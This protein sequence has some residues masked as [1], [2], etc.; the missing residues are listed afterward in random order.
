MPHSTQIIARPTSP[1]LR[2]FR[3]AVSL[4]SH[5]THSM[6]RL[7]H[8]RSIAALFRGLWWTP[9]LAPAPALRLERGQI[10]GLGLRPLVSITDHDNIDAPLLLRA[11]DGSRD[12]PVSVEWTVP[13]GS[14]FFHLG[15]HN[16]PPRR[17][18][19]RMRVL[20]GFTAQPNAADLPGILDWLAEDPSV[21]IV[22]NHPLWDEKGLAPGE[23]ERAAREF[24]RLHRPWIHALELNGLRPWSDNRRVLRWARESS[25]PAVAG[26]DRHGCEPNVLLN[27]TNACTFHEFVEEVRDEGLSRVLAMPAY[28]QPRGRRITA[29]VLSVFSRQADGSRWTD[30]VLVQ[31]QGTLVS[32]RELWARPRAAAE[33]PAAFSTPLQSS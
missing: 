29:D 7:D 17:A 21:L 30:R 12:M 4:H 22:F 5:T 25:L 2:A 18:T 32:L 9:P 10:E 19:D 15:L 14:T 8:V 33:A 3:A 1:R 28:R 13:W 6:E 16:L 24:L 23:H 11:Q 27:V 31:R 26:G 20:A